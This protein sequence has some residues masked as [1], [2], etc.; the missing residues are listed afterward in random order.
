MSDLIDVYATWRNELRPP[1][2]RQKVRPLATL[3]A[4]GAEDPQPGLWRTR[5]G[6]KR[7]GGVLVPLKIWIQDDEGE[8]IHKLKPGQS[9]GLAGIM[10]G[11]QLTA[12]QI[13]D[14]WLGCQAISKQVAAYYDEHKRWPEDA[15]LLQSNNPPEDA[16]GALEAYMET[17]A[18]WLASNI[19]DTAEKANIASNMGKELLRLRKVADDER[20][21]KIRPH[22]EAQREV[23]RIYK[24]LIDDATKLVDRVGE[25]QVAWH[26][27]EKERREKEAR[28]QY[29]REQ[30]EHAAE[31]ERI[32]K[33]RAKLEREDPIAAY[34]SPEPEIP[35]PPMMQEPERV[36]TG[37][38][39]GNRMSLRVETVFDIEDYEKVLA[40]VKTNPKVIEVVTQ[41]AR[42]LAKAG[43]VL[44]GVV[45]KEVEKVR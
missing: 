16:I 33:E 30:R 28:E 5:N 4:G 32:Q 24:P 41:V 39:R 23:N 31:V 40:Q 25:A 44:D 13:A 21:A 36:K 6:A 8:Q 45:A 2:E 14:R 38:A 3:Y 7:D 15:P 10:D 29:E 11:R 37:G 18:A 20:D 43:N 19:V 27:A 9:F 17:T 34:T 35:P 26:K 12:K 1:N 22:L 42:A